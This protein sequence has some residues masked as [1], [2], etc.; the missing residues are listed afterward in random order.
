[1]NSIK[2][3]IALAQKIASAVA[4][5][6]GSVYYVG[7]C[8]RDRLLG[9]AN[10]DIDI[11]VH[12]ITVEQLE[13]IL[14]AVGERVQFGKSFGIYS[15]KGCTVDIAMPRK[16]QCTGTKHTD[17]KVDI[18]PFL[19]TKKAAER[20]D[21]TVNALMENVLTGEIVD[22]FGGRNDLKQGVIRHINDAAFAEDPLRVLRGAQFAA[23]FGFVIAPETAQLCRTIDISTLSSER[24]FEELK[25]ALLKAQKPSVFFEELYKMNHLSVW[26][27]EVQQL[28]GVEQNQKYHREGDVFRH[29]MMVLDEAAKR[30]ELVQNPVGFMLSAL[31]HDFGK[32]QASKMID[33]VMHAYG[34]EVAGIP[35]AEAFLRKI[36]SEKE[37]IKY[38]LNMVEH[39]M[40]PN[41]AA[42]NNSSVKST[43]KMFDASAMPRDLILLA[44][45]DSL[46]KLP[47]GDVEAS[48]KFLAQRLEIFEEYMSRPYVMGRDLI[49][50]GLKP[51]NGFSALLDLAHKLRLAGV[52]KDV[53]L[54]QVLAEHRIK[55]S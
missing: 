45:C 2:N 12:G 14:D 48:Q 47:R 30:R 26:F 28:M 19:G 22:H 31:A 9:I 25:K 50:A 27:C 20:R 54:K 24:V 33:G 7:G 42:I 6:G 1:M 10:K 36:T 44:V 55:K 53:A 23:R 37:L 21:F 39:H 49:E 34:H 52:T 16:E 11:E 40:K 46:G 32:V 15:L 5:A 17:F 8:V 4:D 18:D 38:V 3:D 41:V 29:T 51:D 13:N 35:V 43:N